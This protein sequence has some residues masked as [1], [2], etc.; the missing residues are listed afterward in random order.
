MSSSENIPFVDG[1][2]LA[3][4]W[5]E[6]IPIMDQDP[7]KVY[8]FWCVN[9]HTFRTTAVNAYKTLQERGCVV[10]EMCLRGASTSPT[11][12]APAAGY[13]NMGW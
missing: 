12:M 3:P 9:G 6:Q 1:N 10:C 8:T 2:A 11:T 7:T 5:R 4:Y 13:N